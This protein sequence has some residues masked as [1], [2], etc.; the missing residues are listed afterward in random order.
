ILRPIDF[1]IPNASIGTFAWD[2]DYDDPE[3]VPKMDSKIQLLKFWQKSQKCLDAF[4]KY[5]KDEYLLSMRERFQT[6][7]KSPRI[8]HQTIPKEGEIVLI[9]QETIPRGSWK[10]GRINKL[11]EGHDQKVRSADV[12]LPNG[13]CL[14]RPINLLYPVEANEHKTSVM[15]CMV[16][17]I[18]NFLLILTLIAFFCPVGLTSQCTTQN[19]TLLTPV[20]S[21]NCTRKGI[22]IFKVD[23]NH[24]C[25]KILECKTTGHLNG[26]GACREA[27]PC[28]NWAFRCSYPNGKTPVSHGQIDT[29]LAAG[30]VEVCSFKPDAKCAKE[31][32]LERMHQIQLFNGTNLYVN[33]LDIQWVET[34][35]ENYSCIGQ[36]LLTGTPTFC[37]NHK[38]KKR[39]TQFCYYETS[40]IAYYSNTAGK[41]PIKAYGT[42]QVEVYRNQHSP[43]YA[44][45]CFECNLQCI[46]GGVQISL[47]KDISF[48]E[49]CSKPFCYKMSFPAEEVNFMLPNQINLRDH[50]I[51]VKIWP[52]GILVK[53]FGTHC[54]SQPFCETLNCYF[55][56]A[57]LRNP[58]CSSTIVLFVILIGLYFL[59]VTIYVICKVLTIVIQLTKVTFLCLKFFICCCW[60]LG[61]RARNR[62]YRGTILPLYA[63]VDEETEEENKQA[64]EAEDDNQNTTAA[65]PKRKASPKLARLM[66]PVFD[67]RSYKTKLPYFMT[68]V[69][70]L[71]GP[72]HSCSEVSTM[73]AKTSVCTMMKNGAMECT[74]NEVTRLALAPQGQLSCL[75]LESPSGE[76]LG[77]IELEVQHISL[78]CQKKSK[79]FSRSY[80]MKHQAVKRCP[81]VGS[82][83]DSKCFIIMPETILEEFED[84]VNESPGHTYCVESCGG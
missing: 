81:S 42:I 28:P 72:S 11:I 44:T 57:R 56:L 12:K 9:K 73:V 80:R 45:T 4:W 1:L 48:M 70:V 38:C 50:D 77:S 24:L 52:N 8:Q 53:N 13:K 17:N 32:T 30:H 18:P 66:T 15:M 5:W 83:Y 60:K 20:Y 40:E 16:R 25:W 78:S 58:Q 37:A 22:A 2:E 61:K 34:T 55:C 63:M 33:S 29:I 46:K 14:T 69:A 41:I 59:S 82:C 6:K 23:D 54:E 27:C 7:H 68:L 21:H 10:M 47:G 39:G 43:A 71:I 62:T 19:Q 31:P 76:P 65:Q 79:Y 36:G 84:H 75:L 49:I 67:R 35:T 26:L 51:T 74:M 64:E 3:Y